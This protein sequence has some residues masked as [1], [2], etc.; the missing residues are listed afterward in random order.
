MPATHQWTR[1][2]VLALPDDGNRYELVDGELLVSPSPRGVHQQAVLRLYD[3]VAPYVRRHRIG[4]IMLA[5]ADLDLRSGQLVQPDLYVVPL[6]PDGREPLEWSE[7]DVPLLI[8]EVTSPATA[9][10]DRIVKRFRFQRSRVGEYWIVD[11]DAR[12]FERWTPDEDRPEVLHEVVTWQ[13]REGIEPLVIDVI[14]YFR[15]VWGER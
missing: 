1:E 3:R 4:S 15:E 6:G 8:A 2:E 12:T 13:A 7:Y 9:R 11:P 5:P 14:D 10:Y